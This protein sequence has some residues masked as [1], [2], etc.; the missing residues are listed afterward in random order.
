MRATLRL[1]VMALYVARQEIELR[2][3]Q[4][5]VRACITHN[6]IAVFD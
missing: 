6:A 4:P 3:R 2:I 1:A 5:N